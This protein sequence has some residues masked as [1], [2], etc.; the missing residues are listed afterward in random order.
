MK[1]ILLISNS[2]GVDG[3]RYLH[4]IARK[5]GEE[6]SVSCLYIGGCS[7]YRHY[8]NMLSDEAAYTLYFNG[9]ATPYKLSLKQALLADEWDIVAL[10][11]VSHLS[12]DF[13]S[14]EPFLSEL[15]AYVKKLAPFAKQYINAIWAY[16]DER[17]A[18]REAL[19]YK[20][21]AEMTAADHKG[22][23]EAARKINADGFVPCTAAME[24]LYSK[25]GD[26]TYRDGAHASSGVGRYMLALVWFGTVFGKSV[27]GI[28]YRDFDVE[29]SE[30][31]VEIAEKCAAEAIAENIYKKA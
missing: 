26:A 10:Q 29:V 13:S 9:F 7:L 11:Q 19:V 14:Y 24:K 6:V 15:S 3:T 28:G 30:E 27:E 5:A 16:S 2:F 22:Y 31:Y 18:T 12:G 23:A 25:I 21:N 17:I 4:G 8:R 1:K 20:T